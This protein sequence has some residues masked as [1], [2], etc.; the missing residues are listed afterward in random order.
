MSSWLNL[1]FILNKTVPNNLIAKINRLDF[2]VFQGR[3]QD[4]DAMKLSQSLKMPFFVL[5]RKKRENN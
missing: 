1:T 3:M 2:G 5:V 4:F